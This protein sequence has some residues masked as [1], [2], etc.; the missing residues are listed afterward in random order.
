MVQNQGRNSRTLL[1]LAHD[2]SL[3]WHDG[4]ALPQGSS[5]IPQPDQL[6][7]CVRLSSRASGWHSS[8]QNVRAEK[9]CINDHYELHTHTHTYINTFAITL[10]LALPC[11]CACTSLGC[12]LLSYFTRI[13][14][15][16]AVDDP[17]VWHAANIKVRDDNHF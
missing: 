10:N 3:L 2:E 4:R 14:F 16:F 12:G 1:Q 5:L 15:V 8:R 9:D 6:R 17:M 11:C 13:D 7:V